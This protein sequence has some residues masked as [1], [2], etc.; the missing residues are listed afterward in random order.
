M[1]KERTKTELTDTIKNMVCEFYN[2]GFTSTDIADRLDISISSVYRILDEYDLRKIAKKEDN[3]DT[4]ISGKL[5][6]IIEMLEGMDK[7]GNHENISLEA[8][9]YQRKDERTYVQKR[10]NSEQRVITFISS[11]Q[12]NIK[13]VDKYGKSLGETYFLNA[14]LIEAMYDAI[15]HRNWTYFGR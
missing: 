6:T 13:A 11:Q 10:E 1:K 15:V 12:I 2:R 3:T 4:N 14:N 5:D 9:G 8:L 7:I